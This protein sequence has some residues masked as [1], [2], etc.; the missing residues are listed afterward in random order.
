MVRAPEWLPAG[1]W[2]AF[3]LRFEASPAAASPSPGAACALASPT[4]ATEMSGTEQDRGCHTSSQQ[5][6]R[7]RSGIGD[8]KSSSQQAKAWA[9]LKRYESSLV[10]PS[11]LRVL[12]PK[13]ALLS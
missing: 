7:A 6:T 13:M 12:T 2:N 8:A 1:F 11:C 4:S 5:P 9:V 3:A 10:D